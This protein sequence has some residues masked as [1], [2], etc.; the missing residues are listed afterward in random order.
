MRSRAV[1]SPNFFVSSRMRRNAAGAAGA[2]ATVIARGSRAASRALRPGPAAAGGGRPHHGP[3]ARR[4]GYFFGSDFAPYRFSH[5]ARMRAR[6]V[7]A[8]WKSF[9][10][11]CWSMLAGRCSTGWAIDGIAVTA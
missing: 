10:A 4:P 7:A 1:N 11:M 2:D 6:F 9:F 3:A 8:H 5:S